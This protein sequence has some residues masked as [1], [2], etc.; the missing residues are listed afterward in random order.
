M[1]G[2]YAKDKELAQ[3]LLNIQLESRKDVETK[4]SQRG[5]SQLSNYKAAH[6]LQSSPMK[7]LSYDIIGTQKV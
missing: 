2:G 1:A 7:E 3:E 4:L 6:S 5:G